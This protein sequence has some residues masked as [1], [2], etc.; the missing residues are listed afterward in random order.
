[1]QH[2]LNSTRQLRRSDLAKMIVGYLLLGVLAS[3]GASR[4]PRRGAFAPAPEISDSDTALMVEGDIAVTERN[5]GLGT[6]LNAFRSA[7]NSLWPRGVVPFRIDTDEWDGIVEP[8]FLDSQIDIITQAHQK[9]ENG[10]PC[11]EF[12]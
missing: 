5:L 2:P 3:C 9:I 1:M 7:Q 10:V 8:V 12:R 11:I 6:P 4:P